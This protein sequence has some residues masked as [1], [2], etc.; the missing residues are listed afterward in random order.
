MVS[1]M[2]TLALHETLEHTSSPARLMVA[3]CGGN[4]AIR[5]P[6]AP[7][8]RKGRSARGRQ[9]S[10]TGANDA[11]WGEGVHK[12]DAATRESI[13]PCILATNTVVSF[14]VWRAPVDATHKFRNH[15]EGNGFQMR[16][17]GSSPR[18]RRTSPGPNTSIRVTFDRRYKRGGAQV[19]GR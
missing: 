8:A 10:S 15:H 11:R 7:Q 17:C 16:D 9:L 19:E 18:V 12:G 1:L 2:D 6:Y 14:R 4:K 13:H 3:A 5:K